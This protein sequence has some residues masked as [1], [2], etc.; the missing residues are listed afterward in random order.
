MG[1]IGGADDVELFARPWEIEHHIGCGIDGSVAA[2]GC[3]VDGHG[4]DFA[5]INE[6]EREIDR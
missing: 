3:I 5:E 2:L 4:H 1:A 6:M